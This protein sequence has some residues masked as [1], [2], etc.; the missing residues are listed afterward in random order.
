MADQFYGIYAGKVMSSRDPIN[1]GRIQ[2]FVPGVSGGSTWA[3]ACQPYKSSSAPPPIGTPVWV[4]FEEGDP[5]YP[6]WM[7]CAADG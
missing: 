1:R 4:M 5:N 7:G 3:A 6:V 2:V